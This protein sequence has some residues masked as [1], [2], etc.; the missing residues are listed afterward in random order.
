MVFHLTGGNFSNKQFVILITTLAPR[1]PNVLPQTTKDCVATVKQGRRAHE[2]STSLRAPNT[3]SAT[4]ALVTFSWPLCA[5][6]LSPVLFCSVLSCLVL[7]CCVLVYQSAT[8]CDLHQSRAR[9][10]CV[11]KRAFKLHCLLFGVLQI[12][13]AQLNWVA[14]DVGCVFLTFFLFALIASPQSVNVR[15]VVRMRKAAATKDPKLNRPNNTKKYYVFT[16]I[17]T[18]SALWHCDDWDNEPPF[19][20][21]FLGVPLLATTFAGNYDIGRYTPWFVLEK[22]KTISICSCAN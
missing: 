19:W 1:K 13:A 16:T 17:C 15:C 20:H 14:G 21:T 8:V 18:P 5:D 10:V 6:L 9:F 12:F 11:L 2:E 4:I 3:K 7:L 22:D